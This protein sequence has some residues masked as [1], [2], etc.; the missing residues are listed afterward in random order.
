M[1][2]KAKREAQKK[3]RAEEM[4]KLLDNWHAKADCTGFVPKKPA[5]ASSATQAGQPADAAKPG[6]D[7]YKQQETGVMRLLVVSDA[8]RKLRQS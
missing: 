2:E 5:Q 1:A 7:L 6:K 8:N 3:K 4:Q